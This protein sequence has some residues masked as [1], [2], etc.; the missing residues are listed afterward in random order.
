MKKVLVFGTF[1]MLH[2]GHISFLK[3][4]KECGDHLI[5]VLGRDA[6]VRKY[7][8]RSPM[9]DEN[10]RLKKIH[11]VDIVDEA[12]LGRSDHDYETLIRKIRPDIICLGYDQDD[13]GLR[14]TIKKKFPK[15]KI[16]TLR[17]YKPHI[18]KTSILRANSG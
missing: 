11:E 9:Q 12:M 17:P 13:F 3:D 5:V 6:N 15:I 14:E 16:K 10:T 2:A 1:D 7:K 4:A 8:K 18:Y